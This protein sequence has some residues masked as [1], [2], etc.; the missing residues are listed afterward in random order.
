L[1][2]FFFIVFSAIVYINPGDQYIWRISLDYT[3]LQFASWIFSSII[4]IIL[5]TQ[6]KPFINAWF[7]QIVTF[8]LLSPFLLLV[9]RYTLLP[10]I[11]HINFSY[12][13]Y[14]AQISALL[15]W[16]IILIMGI[17]L[18][19]KISVTSLKIPEHFG[20]TMRENEVTILVIQ[21]LTNHEIAGKLSVSPETVKKHI[22]NIFQ[23]TNS[24]SK[25]G[26]AN[27]LHQ[28]SDLPD[29]V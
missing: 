8:L 5:L 15:S 11:I 4:L 10:D 20:L 1:P 13:F 23:K 28:I 22:K 12:W 3:I 29:I 7:Q 14:L 21:G 17:R 24:G 27:K 18:N 9:S 6:A 16:I 19:L 2:L 26:L 25:I